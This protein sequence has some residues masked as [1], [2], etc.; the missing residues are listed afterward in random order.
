M[1]GSHVVLSHKATQI[2]YIDMLDARFGDDWIA[3]GI[4]CTCKHVV[5]AVG[6]LLPWPVGMDLDC[7]NWNGEG[8]VCQL[9][10]R[11]PVF[12]SNLTHRSCISASTQRDLDPGFGKRLATRE[13]HC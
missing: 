7:A 13:R 8:E 2:S 3:V 5:V 4:G 1:S 11:H 9:S 6:R 10:P 12:P